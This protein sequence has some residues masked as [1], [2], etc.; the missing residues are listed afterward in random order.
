MNLECHPR[1][2]PWSGVGL[3]TRDGAFELEVG[4]PG[5]ESGAVM[6]FLTFLFSFL[7]FDFT[8]GLAL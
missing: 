8:E 6:R 3:C 4:R 5:F 2:A 7:I 1:G